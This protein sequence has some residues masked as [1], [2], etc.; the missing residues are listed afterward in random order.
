MPLSFLIS[1]LAALPDANAALRRQIHAVGERASLLAS[2]EFR[3]LAVT[4][5]WTNAGIQREIDIRFTPQSSDVKFCRFGALVLRGVLR[6][7]GRLRCKTPDHAPGAVRLSISRDGTVFSDEVTF[8]Y[9]PRRVSLMPFVVIGG[10]IGLA[11]A[12]AF[13]KSKSGRQPPRRT[14]FPVLVAT[15]DARAQRLARPRHEPA[16]FL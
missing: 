14:G 16:A 4:P 11:I 7:D 15:H 9:R 10:A 3:I 2:A 12:I 6:Q 8:T 5:N 1:A 13:V